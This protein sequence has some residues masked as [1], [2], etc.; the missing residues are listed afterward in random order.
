MLRLSDSRN[1]SRTLAVVGLVA[2]PLL[3]LLDALIDP[4][5]DDDNAAYLAEVAA[6]KHLNITA[7]VV[8]TLGSLV[9]I[10]GAI[11]VMRLMRGP[12][13]TLGHVAA[14]LLTVGLIGLT[15]SLAF[16]AFDVAMADFENREAMVAFR[17]ELEDSGAVNAYWLSFFFGGVVSGSILLA[18]ALLRRRIVPVWSPILL[19]VAIVLWS[20]KG[21]EKFLN[22]LSLLILAVALAPLAMRIRSLS[23]ED[24][25]QW[26]VPVDGGDTGPAPPAERIPHIPQT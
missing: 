25:E 6:N 21:D 4:A 18:I 15:A 3:F 17:D 1:F 20:L 8:A 5:W 16:N 19:V 7:E 11:G 22:A 9:F 10:P 24:W 26:T 23:D 2:G 13:V 12:R 14:G